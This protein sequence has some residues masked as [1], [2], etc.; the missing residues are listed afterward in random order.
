MELTHQLAQQLIALEQQA[1]QVAALLDDAP[2]EVL[3]QVMAA[4]APMPD[5]KG[6]NQATRDRWAR[7]WL[8]W[9]AECGGR[10]EARPLEPSADDLHQLLVNWC[11]R[12]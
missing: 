11:C 7:T 1:A 12:A 4:F 2:P 10:Y 6:A 5:I 9:V 3:E 8:G